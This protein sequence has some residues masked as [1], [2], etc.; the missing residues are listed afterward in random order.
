MRSLRLQSKCG[1]PPPLLAPQRSRKQRR[2]NHGRQARGRHH[3]RIVDAQYPTAHHDGPREA[4]STPLLVVL[5]AR[6]RF[7]TQ[8]AQHRYRDLHHK[9]DF[10]PIAFLCDLAVAH[11]DCRLGASLGDLPG[12]VARVADLGGGGGLRSG[13]TFVICPALVPEKSYSFGSCSRFAMLFRWIALDP[14]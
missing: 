4:A 11:V 8:S 6:T 7:P 13:A 10:R 5:Y 3:R 1:V 14:P 12:M 9:R 2:R